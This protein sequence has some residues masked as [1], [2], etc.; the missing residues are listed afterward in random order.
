[1]ELRRQPVRQPCRRTRPGTGRCSAVAMAVGAAQN[2]LYKVL[3]VTPTATA[4]EIKQAFRKKALKLHPDVN[5][6][7]SAPGPARG[8]ALV[9]KASPAEHA[10]P[11]KIPL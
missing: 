7:V 4:A 2:D 8:Q 1:M 11:V 5:A 9:A 10:V 6:A 3:G